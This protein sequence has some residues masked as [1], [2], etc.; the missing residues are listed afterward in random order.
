MQTLLIFLTNFILITTFGQ[1]TSNDNCYTNTNAKTKVTQQTYPFDKADRILLV[2]YKAVAVQGKPNM[3]SWDTVQII[4]KRGKGIDTTKFISKHQLTKSGIDSLLK[5]INKRSKDNIG[6]EG[7][8][9]EPSNGIL[10]F[11]KKGNIF[12]YIIICFS[13]I[14]TLRNY[15]EMSSSY[16]KINLGWWCKDKGRLLTDFFLNRGVGIVVTKW[17]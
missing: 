10:F 5:I 9:V 17:E 7:I 1:T 8:F 4:P 12:E 13:Q 15:T 11:D 2:K 3:F 14:D 16:S 6:M